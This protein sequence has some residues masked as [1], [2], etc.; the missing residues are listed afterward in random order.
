[1]TTDSPFSYS[2]KEPGS[3][4]IS[5]NFYTREF[6]LIGVKASITIVHIRKFF[7]INKKKSFDSDSF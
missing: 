7:E 2:T 1:M 3:S 5:I 4:D 6:I